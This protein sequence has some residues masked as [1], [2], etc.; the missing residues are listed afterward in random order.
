MPRNPTPAQAAAARRNG[1]R[2]GRPAKATS[3]PA[4]KKPPTLDLT[5]K[6]HEERERN[7]QFLVDLRDGLMPG[8]TTLDRLRAVENLLDRDPATA[9]ARGEYDIP[10][11]DASALPKLFELGDLEEF[12]APP[13]WREVPVDNESGRAASNGG[14]ATLSQTTNGNENGPP[15]SETPPTSGGSPESSA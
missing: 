1:Q 6:L 3:Q 5:G 11:A 14:V 2:G 7:F 9:R 15:P 12:D 8:A 4:P 13:G 10:N